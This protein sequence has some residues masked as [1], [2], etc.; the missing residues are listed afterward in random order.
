MEHFDALVVM[1]DI[2]EVIKALEYEMAWIIQQASPFVVVGFFQEHFIGN[3][4][5]QVFSGMDF[6]TEVNPVLIKYIQDGRPSFGQLGESC[7]YQSCGPL[8][9]G[10]NR[11]P[12]QGTTESS[13]GIQSQVGRCLGCVLELLYRPG[14]SGLAVAAYVFRRKPIKQFVIGRVNG[15]QLTLQMG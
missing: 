9:P 12:E 11:M 5:M 1:V 2:T 6:V 10:I 13:M 8:W 7:F 14:C 4:I 3:T 15:H